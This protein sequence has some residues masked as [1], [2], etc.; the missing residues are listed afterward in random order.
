LHLVIII[1]VLIIVATAQIKWFRSTKFKIKTLG[2]IFPKEHEWKIERYEIGEPENNSKD[3]SIILLEIN[4]YLKSTKT[5]DFGVIKDITERYIQSLEDEINHTLT[6]PLYLGLIGTIA[7]VIVGLFCLD[8]KAEQIIFAKPLIDG[9]KIA[10]FASAL[11]LSLTIINSSWFYNKEKSKLENSKN[12]LYQRILS[13]GNLFS[14]VLKG[15][16]ESLGGFNDSLNES[17]AKLEEIWDDVITSNK[18]QKEIISTL[19]D[20]KVEKMIEANVKVFDGLNKSVNKLENFNKYVAEMSLFAENFAKLDDLAQATQSFQQVAENLNE[21][22]KINNE[23]RKSIDENI[24][25]AE[26]SNILLNGV[27]HD[28]GTAFT[29]LS[30][31]IKNF[32]TNVKDS[33]DETIRNPIRSTV[34]DIEGG[35]SDI[36]TYLNKFSG[37]MKI[38]MDIVAKEVLTY[39]EKL[40]EKT[41]NTGIEDFLGNKLNDVAIKIEEYTKKETK[42]LGEKIANTTQGRDLER[43]ISNMLDQQRQIIENTKPRNFIVIIK[44]FFGISR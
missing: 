37:D 10:M 5:P 4:K 31:H 2:A 41:K 34:S 6:V 13:D 30:S 17:I 29:E 19:K 32:N 43:L 3:L 20:V 39:M 44:D 7:G 15:L 12:E 28:I 21:N 27:M 24:N 11:G 22:I 33:I 35:F 14:D 26:R 25:V 18:Q 40:N 16:K 36:N 23:W 42:E 9:I 1:I 38:S 8:L